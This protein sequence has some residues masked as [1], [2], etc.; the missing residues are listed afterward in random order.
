MTIETDCPQKLNERD[1]QYCP[2]NQFISAT[3]ARLLIQ[4]QATRL[5]VVYRP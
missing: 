4:S 5:Q 2:T 3:L 1:N